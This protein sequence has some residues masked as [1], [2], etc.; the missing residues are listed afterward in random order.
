MEAYEFENKDELTKEC[1]KLQL[2][3]NDFKINFNV[4]KG[5]G[6]FSTVYKAAL[7]RSLI[8][9]QKSMTNDN[10]SSEYCIVAAKLINNYEEEEM[11]NVIGEIQAVQKL[12][13]HEKICTLLRWSTHSGAPCLFFELMEM[14]L[15]SYLISLRNKSNNLLTKDELVLSLTDTGDHF[16]VPEFD[17]KQQL[18]F[19][20]ILWQISLGLEYIASKRIVHRDVAARNILLSR[21]NN[22]ETY[23]AKITDFGLCILL[24]K[25][26]NTFRAPEF[27]KFPYKWL[28]IESLV[29]RIFSQASDIWAFG[30][31]M[32]EIYTC[33]GILYPGIGSNEIVY[34]LKHDKRMEKPKNMSQEMYDLAST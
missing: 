10:N 30:I 29:D 3:K 22:T 24:E 9:S 20:Q 33:A 26:T 25:D 7:K 14:D 28:A 21:Y 12:G 23:I 4:V 31:L 15:Q 13:S 11:F 34:F 1:N 5:R 32:M 27:K 19:M 2:S 6:A 16:N 17:R 8:P 18:I